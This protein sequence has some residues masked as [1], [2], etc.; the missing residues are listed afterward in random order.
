MPKQFLLGVIALCVFSGCNTFDLS[1]STPERDFDPDRHALYIMGD[2][3]GIAYDGEGQLR[4][5]S[6]TVPFRLIKLGTG[7]MNSTIA[8]TIWTRVNTLWWFTPPNENRRA[9]TY[10]RMAEWE[11]SCEQMKSRATEEI[12][13]GSTVDLYGSSRGA[14]VVLHCAPELAQ[15]GYQI[16]YVALIDGGHATASMNETFTSHCPA[17]R[18]AKCQAYLELVRQDDPY[19]NGRFDE[20]AALAEQVL[21]FHALWGKEHHQPLTAVFRDDPRV[22]FATLRGTHGGIIKEA[23][24]YVADLIPPYSET[25]R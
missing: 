17:N 16:G 9:E 22:T 8:D 24:Q 19:H 1:L 21:V 4:P 25:Q 6:R 3:Y 12:P 7:S 10:H 18:Q 2:N 5:G 14:T 13:R 23:V 11:A 20:T 15:M